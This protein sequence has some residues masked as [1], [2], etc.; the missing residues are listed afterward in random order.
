VP[1]SL[2]AKTQSVFRSSL[3]RSPAGARRVSLSPSGLKTS[4]KRLWAAVAESFVLN[5]SE[6]A[7]LEQAC[8]TSDELDR[9]ERA[10]RALP[11]LVVEGSTGQPRS[12]PLLEEVRRHR[13]LLE[14]LTASLAL[15]D[16]EE[17][18]GLKPSQKHAQKA[19]QGR[20]A[21]RQLVGHGLRRDEDVEAS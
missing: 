8:R 18:S 6:T 2:F 12:H 7:L 11:S 16:A 20:W 9:L 10:V 21:H 17:E 4:G 1:S 15:P 13:V 3:L 14:R 5:P 19:A